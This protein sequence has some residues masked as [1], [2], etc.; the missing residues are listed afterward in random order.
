MSPRESLNRLAELLRFRREQSSENKPVF[1][2]G[3]GCSVFDGVPLN[4]QLLDLALAKAPPGWGG[5]QYRFDRLGDWM[6]RGR[7]RADY[8][9]EFFEHTIKPDSPYHGLVRLAQ[10]GHVDIICTF[11]IDRM[12]DQAF[13]AA[14]LRE[15]KDYLIIDAVSYAP[16]AVYELVKLSSPRIK[17]IKVHGDYRSGFNFMTSA[18]IA[19]YNPHIH[20]VVDSI[21]RRAAIVCGYSFFHLNVLN[22]FSRRGGEFFFVNRDFPETPIVLSLMNLRSKTPNFIDH[23]SGLFENFI[24]ELEGTLV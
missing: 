17:V 15:S 11:N 1:W 10:N 16:D 8:L 5:R 2:L 3:A 7:D 6:P 22:A 23:P 21:S 20:Q 4:E 19:E 24:R 13:D 14:G 9:K 12:I 18:E